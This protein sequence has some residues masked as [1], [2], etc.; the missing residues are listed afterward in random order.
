M[1][2]CSYNQSSY[3]QS[4]LYNAFIINY[5]KN[6]RCVSIDFSQIILEDDVTSM[7]RISD[8]VTFSVNYLVVVLSKYAL[9]VNFTK[10]KT[11]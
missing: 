10:Q 7:V 3:N 2:W 4:W 8:A 1:I 9:K 6:S 5:S 11:Y